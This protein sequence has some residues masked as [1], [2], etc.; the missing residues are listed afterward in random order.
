M[1]R[2]APGRA[3]FTLIELLVAMTVIV[4]LATIALAVIPDALERDRTTDAAATIRQ[5]LMIAKARATR[6]GEG[7]GIRFIL[8][9]GLN[10]PTRQAAGTAG[11]FFSSEMQYIE[12]A[13]TIVMNPLGLTGPTDPYVELTNGKTATLK[14]VPP[15]SELIT[16]IQNDHGARWFPKLYIPE[17]GMDAFGHKYRFEILKLDPAGGNDWTLTMALPTDEAPGIHTLLGGGTAVRSYRF[18]VEPRSRPLLGEPNIPLP[19]NVC[20]D[21]NEF[22]SRPSAQLASGYADPIDFEIMFSQNGQVVYPASSGTI[23]LWVRDYTKVVNV[24]PLTPNTAAPTAAFTYAPGP[25][26]FQQGGEQQL[27]AIKAK[28]GSMGV[29]P[30]LAP[31]AAGAYAPGVN[32]YFFASKEASSP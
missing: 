10:D 5:H 4:V 30:V 17:L 23:Y 27:V 15:G 21:L 19:K 2:Q 3:G 18:A 25:T 26:Q 6:E 9:G 28:T 24:I 13:P 22:V 14:N 11:K 16:V 31:D 8:D 20:V 7:R 1:P 32:P 12:A 29:F